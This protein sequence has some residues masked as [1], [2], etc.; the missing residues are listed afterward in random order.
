MS[1]LSIL[2]SSFEQLKD[3]A[4]EATEILKRDI[5]KAEEDIIKKEILPQLREIVG[6]ALREVRDELVLVVD[7]KPGQPV[8]LHLSREAGVVESL[9]DAKEIVLDEEVTH[10]TRET[11]EGK[12][13]RQNSYDLTVTF[14]DGT[15]VSEPKAID[16]FQKAIEKIGVERVRKAT[17]DHNIR[18]S[19][20]P[21]ISNRRDSKYTTSQRDL[22][23]GLYLICHGS[24][25]SKKRVLD[26]LSERLGLRLAVH[27]TNTKGADADGEVPML[28]EGSKTYDKTSGCETPAHIVAEDTP[29]GAKESQR[30]ERGGTKLTVKFPDGTVISE[31]MAKDTLKKAIEK[32]GVERVRQVS[33]EHGIGF[34]GIPLVSDRQSAK[35]KSDH[36]PIGDGLFLITKSNNIGKRRALNKLS[37]ILGLG[38]TVT[39]EKNGK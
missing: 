24:N 30:A 16:T 35:Y 36:H 14:P 19:R 39:V 17:I 21:L 20:V 22:G 28:T 27:A 5:A 34:S 11:R 18:L 4:P 25:I 6:D 13:T 2:Y 7:Y 31:P 10:T 33:Q 12:I 9:T 23:D 8:S 26:T 32:I 29:H 15:T 37:D 1:N 3:I 38:L